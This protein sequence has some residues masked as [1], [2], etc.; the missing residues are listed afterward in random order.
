MKRE[1]YYSQRSGMRRIR[2]ML[3]ISVELGDESTRRRAC[4]DAVRTLVD[5]DPIIIES[6][7]IPVQSHIGISEWRQHAINSNSKGVRPLNVKKAGR[8]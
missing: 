2:S 8:K 3:R 6:M 1:D 7:F 5:I 4:A